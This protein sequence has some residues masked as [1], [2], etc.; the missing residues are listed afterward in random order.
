MAEV[1]VLSDLDDTR[2][3]SR[4]SG[5]ERLN[6]ERALLRRQLA[7]A[8]DKEDQEEAQRLL[9]PL[10]QETVGKEWRLET[11]SGGN[12]WCDCETKVVNIA[13]GYKRNGVNADIAAFDIE[14]TDRKSVV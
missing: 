3:L 9:L 7:K 11:S 10:L 1:P 13:F 4:P 5:L 2:S 14:A 8:V 12:A 6:V